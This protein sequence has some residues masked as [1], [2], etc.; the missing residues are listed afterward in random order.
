MSEPSVSV[1]MAVRNGAQRLADAVQSIRAQTTA[2]HEVVLIDGAST[3]GTRELAAH[4]GLRVLAQR[5]STLA[6]A[7]TEGVAATSGTHIAF[8]SYD[9]RWLPR[10]TELQLA[11]LAAEPGA[12]AVVGL[13]HF[14]VEAGDTAPHGFRRELL[15]APRPARIM[16]TLLAPR[17]T[18]E[19]VGPF[20]AEVSPAD[21]TDW[22]ARAADL[23]LRVAIVDEVVL[24][25]R[26]HARSNAHTEIDGT[27]AGLLR[28]LRDS[29]ERKRA[30]EPEAST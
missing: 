12:D 28:L 7:Y 18:F 23:G 25:K 3:D 10:K 20:R 9:D 21:D 30:A 4:L 11:R 6:D 14:V 2:M 1:V 15:D 16:E 26:V 19:R 17:A 13:A 27:H 8:L 5:G 22:F 24:R 29:I